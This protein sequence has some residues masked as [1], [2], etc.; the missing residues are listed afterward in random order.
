MVL[1]PNQSAQPLGQPAYGRQV[2][3][4]AIALAMF[5]LI[6]S[7]TAAWAVVVPPGP[8]SFDGNLPGNGF[9][10]FDGTSLM[11]PAVAPTATF[12]VSIDSGALQQNYPSSSFHILGGF[13]VTSAF[14]QDGGGTI[15]PGDNI[16]GSIGSGSFNFTDTFGTIL[17]G[18]FTSA[19]F[20]T[21]VGATAGSV[22]T[23]NISG[24]VLTPGPA[25]TFDSS[26]VSAI[27]LA[28]TG[29][30]ISL[31][32]IP[33][34]I[35]ATAIGAPLGPFI[36]AAILAFDPSSGSAVVSGKMTVVPEP[37]S[38]ALLSFGAFALAIPAWRRWRRK[39]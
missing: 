6:F 28:P 24:L 11:T 27:A 22:Q 33:G 10:S 20:T 34:G 7:P 2:A 21:S 9:V 8:H 17:S 23:S 16:F 12:G 14:V 25:F 30:S 37:G 3:A 4:L 19:T 31:S 38:L 5:S 29:F 13:S 15:N 39:G 18:S 1:R 32:S 36:P 26:F 35:A